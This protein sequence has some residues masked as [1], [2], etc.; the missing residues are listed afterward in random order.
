[1][2]SYNNDTIKQDFYL[3]LSD[4]K[5]LKDISPPKDVSGIYIFFSFDL[6]NSTAFKKNHIW[7]RIFDE[8]FAVCKTKMDDFFDKQT[9]IWKTQGGL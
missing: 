8:F 5:D 7:V 2:P 6:V 9:G 3:K 1:M 4:D